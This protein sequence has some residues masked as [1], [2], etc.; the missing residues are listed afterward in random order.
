MTK[1]LQLICVEWA[2]RA[3]GRDHINNIPLRGLRLAEEA[4]E[5]AQA[6]DVSEDLLHKL[7]TLVYSRPRGSSFYEVGG[8]KVTLAVLCN[9]LGIDEDRAFEYELRRVLA[10]PLEHF[11]QRNKEKLDLGLD[12][13]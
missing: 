2:E 5:L 12:V 8:L 3:F 4:I 1:G 13:K 11:A 6:L 10:K 9:R 7:V